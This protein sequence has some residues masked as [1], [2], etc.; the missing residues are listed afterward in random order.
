MLFPSLHTEHKTFTDV[1]LV[2]FEWVDVINEIDRR[3]KSGGE[4]TLLS[5]FGMVMKDC[6][7]ITNVK[8]AMI[9]FGAKSVDC[10][11]SFSEHSYTYGMHRDN[12]DVL[13]WQV[14]GKT[15]WITQGCEYVLSSNDLI[16]IP[17]EIDHQVTPLTPRVGISFGF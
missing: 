17:K 1:T 16:F 12:C 15:K 10:Y 4:I 11:V 14:I 6:A 2:G 8:D 3:V 9:K 13:F 5:N 7:T